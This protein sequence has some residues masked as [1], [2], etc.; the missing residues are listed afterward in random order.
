MIKSFERKQAFRCHEEPGFVCDVFS[1]PKLQCFDGPEGRWHCIGYVNERTALV[2]K[3]V[4]KETLWMVRISE[5]PGP[6]R[7]RDIDVYPAWI[8]HPTKRNASDFWK[9]VRERQK[10]HDEI[11]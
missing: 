3:Q 5:E 9:R 11:A 6:R 1:D 7:W 2:M 8:Y 4:A 10:A